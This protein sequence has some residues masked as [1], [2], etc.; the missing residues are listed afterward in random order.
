MLTPTRRPKETEVRL[1]FRADRKA[2]Y[3]AVEKYAIEHGFEAMIE[4][5]E[6]IASTYE[7]AYVCADHRIVINGSECTFRIETERER[8]Y[9]K[10]ELVITLFEPDHGVLCT[11]G[12]I[13]TPS[14]DFLIKHIG[15]MC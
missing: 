2:M 14:F 1:S 10:E 15:L 5:K 8:K 11:G 6:G 13:P 7:V 9:G 3:T 4:K 12:P